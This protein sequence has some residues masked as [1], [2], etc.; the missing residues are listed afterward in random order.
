ME[1]THLYHSGCLIELEEH[2][3]LFDYYQGD[4]NININKPLYVFVSHNHYDHYNHQIFQ[5]NHPQIHYILSND[6]HST[7]QALYVKPHQ[8]YQV[9]DIKINTL[10]STDQGVAYIIEVE[11]Q[12]IYF[13]GD[14]HWWHWNDE[15]DMSNE[16]QRKIYQQEIN[17]IHQNIDLACIVVDKRQEDDY[18]LG[19]QYFMNQ[20][21]SRY[22]LPIHYFGDYSISQLLQREQLDNPY[23]TQILN[24]THQNQTFNI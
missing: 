6:I 23:Q 16:W 21:K 14:L 2:Q 15:D 4:L 1:V 3:L 12:V 17:R 19:L 18:L 24:V 11:N 22:I 8:T 7:H 20:V 9:D 13:A 5:I 10:L